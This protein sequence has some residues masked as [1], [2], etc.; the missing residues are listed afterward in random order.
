MTKI[1]KI[2]IIHLFVFYPFSVLSETYVCSTKDGAKKKFSRD[3]NKGNFIVEPQVE[4]DGQKIIKE[5]DRFIILAIT[6]D[7][8]SILITIIHK[9]ELTFMENILSLGFDTFDNPS[10]PITGLCKRYD[11]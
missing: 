10:I 2:F 7:F 1:I 5:T 4:K 9:V 11:F 6:P 3:I 8:P